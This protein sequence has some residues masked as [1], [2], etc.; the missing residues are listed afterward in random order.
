[1]A[2]YTT[3]IKSGNTKKSRF[4]KRSKRNYLSASSPTSRIRSGSKNLKRSFSGRLSPKNRK[5]LKKAMYATISAFVLVLFIGFIFTLWYLQKISK[6]LPSPDE[7]FGSKNVASVIYDRN[8]TQLYKVY[9]NENRDPL[10]L[11]SDEAKITEVVPEHVVWAFL[12][13]EDVNFYDHSGFD[14]TSMVSC[15]VKNIAG[16]STCGGSTV[17]QQLVKQTVLTSERRLERKVK[18]LLLSMQVERL[19]TKDQILAMY[20]TVAP[21]GSNVYGV[22]TGAKFYF[23][24]ELKDLTIAEAAILASLP[25][26]PSVLSPTLSTAPEKSEAMLAAR[27]EYVLSQMLRHKDKI[28]KETGIDDLIT[29][30]KIEEA[31]NQ[32]LAYQEPRIDIKAPHF[33]FY[34]QQLLQERGYN[35]G[36]P[37]TLAE[38][39]TGGYKIKTTLDYTLQQ[40]AESAVTND[41]IGVYGARYGGHNAAL[42]TTRPSTG[43]VLA[44]VGSKDYNG[45]KEEKLFDPKVDI[46]TSL[47]QPGSSAKPITYYN[48]FRDAV[49]A[50]GTQLMDIPISIG[51]YTPKNS[52]GQFRGLDSVRNHLV[53]SRNIP[54]LILVEATGVG[55]YI[56]TANKFGYTTFTDVSNYGPSITLGA[57]DVK[58]T[59]HAQAFGVFA[60]SGDFVQQEVVLEIQD[61][62]GKVIYEHKP[63]RVTVADKQAVFLVNDVLRGVPSASPSVF[64]GDGRQVAAKTGT[65]EEQKDTWYVMYSPDFVTVGWLGNNDNTPM[66]RGAFGSTSVKPWVQKYM[67]SIL[68]YFPE[69]TSFS[70]PGGISTKQICQT[71]NGEKLCSTG[72]DLVI[73]DRMPPAYLSKKKFLVCDDQPDRIAREIDQQTGHAVEK[74]FMTYIMPVESLQKFANEYLSG[75][76]MLTPTEMCTIERSPNSGKPWATISSPTA[77][78]T[79]SDNLSISFNAFTASGIITK[80]NVYIDGTFVTEV[81]NLPYNGSIS[82]AD[83]SEGAHTLKLDVHDSNGNVGSNSV[84]FVVS[85]GSFQI[86]SPAS[87]GSYTVPLNVTAKYNGTG[88]PGAVSLCINSTCSIS[89]TKSGDNYSATINTLAS[90]THSIFVRSSTGRTSPT[91]QIEIP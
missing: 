44:Y 86:T 89:M 38:L 61:R 81:K 77:G 12:A 57:A 56:D 7:P 17:T 69:K 13:A 33:V 9:S 83:Y 5:R 18:E 15:G 91:M 4:S 76:G 55:K 84:G 40:T 3:T 66:R 62:Y 64:A 71:V 21:M 24:K 73:D 25:Q 1:M 23:G 20:L 58:A 32:E 11:P 78:A 82:L 59:E 72:Q 28:N 54:A 34:V 26:N 22:N 47:Q 50:P 53:D 6:D 90:G 51:N 52:D 19:Y 35:N 43:E 16:T 80:V 65:S 48:A 60:N 27:K 87:S 45:E 49:A 42:I 41:G 88:N 79:Y 30:E 67:S 8:G 75:H 37:F 85:K 70:R 14:V 74:E 68:A 36:Q 2:T 63:E 46:L 31:K 39:E 29:E 10:I